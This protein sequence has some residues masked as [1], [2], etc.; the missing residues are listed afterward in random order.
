LTDQAEKYDGTHEKIRFRK[1]EIVDL[2]AMP[3]AEGIPFNA[4]RLPNRSRVRRWS[5]RILATAAA[6]VLG[7]FAFLQLLGLSGFGAQRLT[8]VAQTELRSFFGPNIDAAIGSA[9]FSVHGP[10]TLTLDLYDVSIAKGGSDDVAIGAETLRLRLNSW[11]LLTGKPRVSGV[12]LQNARVLVGA[13]PGQSNAAWLTGLLN[14]DGLLDPDKLV[15]FAFGSADNI[16]H[17]FAT[18][19]APEVEISDV[20]FELP[21]GLPTRAIAVDDAVFSRQADGV[22]LH[23]VANADGHHA[24]FDAEITSNP[25]SG[26]AE[27]FKL[28][29]NTTRQDTEV[30]SVSLGKSMVSL[31]GQ[32]AVGDQP[33]KLQAI[34][35][36]DGLSVD[37]G[38]R[39]LLAGKLDILATLAVGTGKLEFDRFNVAIGSSNFRM[40][41]AIGPRPSEQ[42]EPPAYRFE[43]VSPDSILAPADSNE[44]PMSLSL[45]LAGNYLPEKQ[46]ISVENIGISSASGRAFGH[47][48]VQLAEKGPPGIELALD[49]AG[50]SVSHVKQLWPWFSAGPARR[51]VNENLFGGT[52]PT[53]SIR[54]AVVPGRLGNGQKLNSDEVSGHFQVAQTRFDIAGLLPPV[55]DAIG[56]VSFAGDDVDITLGSGKV[57]LSDGKTVSASEGRLTIVDA[58]RKPVIGTL[59]IKVAGDAS[60]IAQLASLEPINAMKNTGIAPESL[61]GAVEGT[62]NAKIPMHK[63][64]DRSLLD[65]DVDLNFKN[66]SIAQKVE[67]QTISDANGTIALDKEKAIIKA[68]ANLNGLPAELTLTEPLGGSDVA[69]QRDITIVIDEDAQQKLS[70]T[71]DEFL[72]GTIKLRVAGT[73]NNRRRLEADLTG[74]KLSLPMVGWTKGEGIPAKLS[75]N[76][77]SNESGTNISNF[78]LSGA[79]FGIAGDMVISD[80]ALRSAKFNR[81]QLTRDDNVSVSLQRS[82]KGYTVNVTGESLDARA[83]IRR[84]LSDDKKN[85]SSASTP[86]SLKANVDRVVGFNDVSLNGVSLTYS[87]DSNIT[88]LSLDATTGDGKSVK[89]TNSP[90]GAGRRFRLTADDAGSLLRFLD[91]Y[92]RMQGGTVA[93]SMAVSGGSYA[94][95]IDLRN[96]WI[97]NEPKLGS[98]V[99]SAPSGG[100]RSLNETVKGGIDTSRVQ[101]ER[102][103]ADIEKGPSYLRVANGVLRGPSVGTTFR[104]TIYDENGQMDLTGTFMPAYGL[105]RIFGELPLIGEILGNGRDRGLIG[106]T[107]RLTGDFNA[108][109]LQI[110]PLSVIAPGIFRSIFEFQ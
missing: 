53:G 46:L 78:D 99:S 80:G 14:A 44:P 62:V 6:V 68:K 57:F 102:G 30:E 94:G 79:T 52:V 88:G 25:Q 35:F 61:S 22:R 63:G 93:L 26:A 64:I 23:G 107:Y 92:D 110:N 75:F 5:I 33:E 48:A 71:L 90:D 42:G 1:E 103:F 105:N 81:F 70:P 11:S 32:R 40:S 59:Q 39:G 4:K 38:T 97:V 8:D 28:V 50:M 2:S 84:A 54:F 45:T 85:G 56:T 74:A 20:R 76:I 95:Q 55:R 7:F 36:G 24:E 89:V 9:R 16:S 41:G 82:G 51:W 47:A 15:H 27:K 34:I 37:L 96:F 98:I 3:S 101:F 31:T 109:R 17:L 104:G 12:T 60:A 29:F 77:E 83:L 66:L 18:G 69:R 106:V 91:I 10:G 72:V 108:P 87:A 58:G 86:I 49:V 13:M 67:G 73:E 43:L 100:N 21:E 65:W 19:A